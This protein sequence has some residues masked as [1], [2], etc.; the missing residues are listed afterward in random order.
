MSTNLPGKS[1]TFALILS[2]SLLLLALFP[3]HLAASTLTLAWNSNTEDDLAGYK[4][5]CGTRSRDYIHVVDVGNITYCSLS[6]LEPETR[7][8]FALT[9]YDSSRNESDY[10]AEVSAVT[11]DDPDPAPAP[12]TTSSPLIDDDD[13]GCFIATAAYGSYLDPHVK[14]LRDFRDVFLASNSLG[15]KCVHLYYHCA[16]PI[17]SRIE[18]YG[19][20]KFIIRQ[21]LL[22]LIAMSSL[23]LKT[24]ASPKLPHLLPFL[25]LI[26]T[27]GLST[28][29]RKA[30]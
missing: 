17:A 4:V 21:G 18:K 24:A 1:Q 19:R 9:A 15:R 10:S 5:Y 7:Y 11:G 29:R 16:P 26:S 22:P 12:S 8:Y 14:L 28:Y 23:F 2:V 25:L 3:D 30:R 6:G 20:L 27:M 13:G